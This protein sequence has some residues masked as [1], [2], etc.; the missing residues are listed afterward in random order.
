MEQRF[1]LAV[2]GGGAAGLTA[3]L[4]ASKKLGGRNIIIIEKQSRVGRKLLATGNGRC[5]ISNSHMS[6]DHYH[7]DTDIIDS[8]IGNFSVQQMKHFCSGLGLLLREDSEGRM[9]PFS[10]QASTVLDCMRT[11]IV[12]AGVKEQCETS[13]LSIS[14]EKN[15]FVI[16]TD[17]GNIISENVIFACGS[18]ASPSLGAD[19]SG[20]ALL[21]RI[22]I[23]STPFFPALSPIETIE[24]YKALKGV[25]AKGKVTLTVDGK[26]IREEVGEI[27]FSEK[28]LSGICIFQCSRYVNEYLLYGSVCGIKAKDIR[29]SLDLMNDYPG[30]ELCKYLRSCRNSFADL[31]ASM[32]L[33]GALNKKLSETI[34]SITGIRNKLCKD[35]SEADIRSI[36]D[37]VKGICFTPSDINSFASAQVCAGGINSD[38][39]DPCTLMSKKNEKLYICGEML[40][41]DGDC[42]GYNLHFAI[43]SAILAARNIK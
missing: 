5:N 43:G 15:I 41:V 20:M 39:I 14:K 18:K 37:I 40:N 35:L 24:K 29:I 17:K 33:S 42:G 19:E 31:P 28:A 3:A 10:N 16:K 13:V 4:A 30:D 7:G 23:R 22:G 8:V 26:I 21:K 32:I 2:I 1:K 25:R 27:Q 12:K 38:E 34:V 9:Y 6:K 36:A 11:G